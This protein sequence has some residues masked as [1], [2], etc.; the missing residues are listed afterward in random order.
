MSTVHARVQAHALR[1]QSCITIGA[2]RPAVFLST[3]HACE[4]AHALRLQSCVA[5]G[6]ELQRLQCLCAQCMHVYDLMNLQVQA[7]AL[8]LQS[9][10]AVGMELQGLQCMRAQLYA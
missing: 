9:C 1:L 5:V 10:V 8:R 7:H 2:P 6:M 4:Q 3:V